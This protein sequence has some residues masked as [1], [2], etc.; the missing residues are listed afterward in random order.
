MSIHTDKLSAFIED[1]LSWELLMMIL[2][3]RVLQKILLMILRAMVTAPSH[4]LLMK[5]HLCVLL[6]KKVKSI[7]V[8]LV[9]KVITFVCF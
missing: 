9:V 5:K 7:V 3:L 6:I 8:A 1:R 2:T 4:I